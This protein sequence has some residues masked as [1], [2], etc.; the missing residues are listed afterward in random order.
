MKFKKITACVLSLTLVFSAFAAG[1]YTNIFNSDSVS[2]ESKLPENNIDPIYHKYYA[3]NEES[4]IVPYSI[5]A[6]LE[7]YDF[8]LKN[9]DTIDKEDLENH[10]IVV[11]EVCGWLHDVPEDPL[12]GQITPLASNRTRTHTLNDCKVCIPSKLVNGK[13]TIYITY[14]AKQFCVDTTEVAELV[15]N[16]NYTDASS[17]AEIKDYLPNHISRSPEDIFTFKCDENGET[18]LDV[19]QNEALVYSFNYADSTK[20]LIYSGSDIEN[21]K[22]DYPELKISEVQDTLSYGTDAEVPCNNMSDDTTYYQIDTSELTKEQFTELCSELEES[23]YGND[24]NYARFVSTDS[25]DYLT[26]SFVPVTYNYIEDY[27]FRGCDKTYEEGAWHY[28]KTFQAVDCYISSY[29]FQYERKLDIK[30]F[31]LS[32]SLQDDNDPSWCYL[33]SLKSVV[34]SS[35]T[36]DAYAARTE[37]EADPNAPKEIEYNPPELDHDI[38]MLDM[39]LVSQWLMC[40]ISLTDEQVTYYD[41]TGDGSTNLCDLAMMK[42]YLMHDEVTL[43][44]NK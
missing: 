30:D 29:L 35:D 26:M 21:L 40:D 43:W 27:D 31:D 38:T 22:L 16:V 14:C 2:A 15:V 17:D 23:K 41:V 5:S 3:P 42:Q 4:G 6:T 11:T 39:T 9:G 8:E 10:G 13:N 1:G 32:Y 36:Y 7:N 19:S 34:D 37:W 25:V 44:P 28:Y 20:A 12:C 24:I 18:C 33:Q